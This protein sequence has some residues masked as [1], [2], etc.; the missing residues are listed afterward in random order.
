MAKIVRNIDSVDDIKGSDF[1]CEIEYI[2]FIDEKGRRKLFKIF[3]IV[4]VSTSACEKIDNQVDWDD[5]NF[6]FVV[7]VGAE[8]K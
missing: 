6:H 1:V 2:E 8:L 7:D 5:S 4:P 3:G